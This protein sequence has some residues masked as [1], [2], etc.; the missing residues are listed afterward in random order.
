MKH[1][2]NKKDIEEKIRDQKSSLERSKTN[3][4]QVDTNRPTFLNLKEDAGIK[5]KRH[6]RGSCG[7]QSLEG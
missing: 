5:L 3:S 2:Y 1:I 7:E 4:K 6:A